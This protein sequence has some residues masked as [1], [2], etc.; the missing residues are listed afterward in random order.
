M[1]KSS[2]PF[3]FFFAHKAIKQSREGACKKCIHTRANFFCKGG[4][5]LPLLLAVRTT[6]YSHTTNC[7]LK[8]Q[9]IEYIFGNSNFAKK[10]ARQRCK[11]ACAAR[12]TRRSN[13]KLYLT[14]VEMPFAKRASRKKVLCFEVI[15]A[16]LSKSYYYYTTT[17]TTTKYIWR[18]AAALKAERA[19]LRK[20]L[21]S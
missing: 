17:T 1:Q 6:H 10:M 9:G 19:R 11:K 20:N 2:P 18:K 16:V 21:F 5:S 7:T 4:S 15:L 13:R 3:C 8:H 14:C 12:C